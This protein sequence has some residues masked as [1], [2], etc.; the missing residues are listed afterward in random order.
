MVFVFVIVKGEN[1]GSIGGD[2]NKVVVADWLTV[3]MAER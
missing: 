3:G 1:Y 2:G